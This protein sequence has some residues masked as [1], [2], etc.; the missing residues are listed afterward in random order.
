MGLQV[1]TCPRAATALGKHRSRGGGLCSLK[2]Y[3]GYGPRL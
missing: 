3:S 2:V 1:Q